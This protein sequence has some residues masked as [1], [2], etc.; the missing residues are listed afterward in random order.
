MIQPC[1][2]QQTPPPSTTTLS[3]RNIP[4]HLPETFCIISTQ[5]TRLTKLKCTLNILEEHQQAQT[6]PPGLQI[7]HKC[8][9]YMGNELRQQWED[10]LTNKIYFDIFQYI[11]YLFEC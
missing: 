3:P 7:T 11:P 1:K 8:K 4:P 9:H 5:K 10:I 6:L 2:T